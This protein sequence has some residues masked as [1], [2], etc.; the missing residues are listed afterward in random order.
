MALKGAIRIHIS[1]EDGY[2]EADK[3]VISLGNHCELAELVGMGR[4]RLEISW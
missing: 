3:N 4:Y 1:P 2:R